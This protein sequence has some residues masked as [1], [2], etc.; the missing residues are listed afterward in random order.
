MN[1]GRRNSFVHNLLS[2]V[3]ER[4]KENPRAIRVCR[5]V[6]K[7]T[8]R[9]RGY[10]MKQRKKKTKERCLAQRKEESGA[11]QNPDRGCPLHCGSP[12]R[13]KP[14]QYCAKYPMSNGRCE[15]HGGKSLAGAAHP[16]FR[17]GRDSKYLLAR[18]QEDYER[19]VKDETL[20][21]LVDEIAMAR[22]MA[23]EMMDKGGSLVQWQDAKES[24]QAFE[25]AETQG[26]RMVARK[27]RQ[28]HAAIMKQGGEGWRNR[29]QI[30]DTF[31][32][33]RR[34]VDSEH[35]HR[36]DN[37]LAIT[38][39]QLATEMAAVAALVRKHLKDEE[40]RR[41]FLRELEELTGSIPSP[42]TNT[43]RVI[44]EK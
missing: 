10:P 24:W 5:N 2:I 26:G 33:L 9:K 21:T 3:N 6:K 11:C 41:A 30:L 13:G 22:V 39:E 27:Y 8:V 19:N 16:N 32:R 7:D 36:S 23:Q 20:R 14:G 42:L 1:R 15:R 25:R 17:H 35:K 34:L 44:D 31:E 37:G 29:A 38:H 40:S 18:L 43:L 4:I 28:E 12:K